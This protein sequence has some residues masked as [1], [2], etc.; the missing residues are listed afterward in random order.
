MNYANLLFF[1]CLIFMIITI[2]FVI[3]IIVLSMMKK[4][5]VF[6]FQFG[7]YKI[8]NFIFIYENEIFKIELLIDKIELKL[9]WFRIRFHISGIKA[10]AEIKTGS[11]AE[12]SKGMN[13][14][15][16]NN[17]KGDEL[18]SFS[19]S[20]SMEFFSEIFLKNKNKFYNLINKSKL[21]KNAGKST[22][23]NLNS[24]YVD[25]IL[26]NKKK[27]IKFYEKIIRSMLSYFD[28]ELENVNAVVKLTDREFY[29]NVSI[30]RILAGLVQG[31]NKVIII[32]LKY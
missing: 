10:L 21:C 3:V 19:R 30:G 12:F 7:F 31:K 14:D 13:L 9:V 25:H 1:L 15:L 11:L 23:F 26:K 24:K 16:K 5:F 4:K 27:N 8:T 22:K 29:H 18:N 20:D 2:P 32:L 28:V 17:I 6:Y